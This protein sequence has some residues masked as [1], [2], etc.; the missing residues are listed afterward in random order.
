MPWQ[1][2]GRE[3][4][5]EFADLTTA[6][7]PPIGEH[8]HVRG[9][10]PVAII[11]LDLAC[12][13][14]AAAWPR[15]RELSLRLC[16]RH[17]PVAAKRPRALALHAAAEAA[18]LQRSDAF[19]GMWDAIYADHGHLDDPHLWERARLLGLDLKRFDADR[20]SGAVADRVRADFE[21]GIRAGVTATPT[22]FAYGERIS[23]E[24]AER[25]DELR[26]V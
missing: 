8:D 18:G 9:E 25:L 7:V 20:R 16:A 12:P 14:C 2:S 10:G 24:V 15:L 17:F 19:W 22:A 4:V 3:S 13:H 6:P 1:R 11:Y 26:P 21:T 5:R 23:G